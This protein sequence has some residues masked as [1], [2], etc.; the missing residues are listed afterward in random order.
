[1]NLLVILFVPRFFFMLA[2]YA[3]HSCFPYIVINNL[4]IQILDM[5]GLL[6]PLFLAGSYCIFGN[7]PRTIHKFIRSRCIV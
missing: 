4:I 3:T 2:M 1:M 6:T 7:N 5:R